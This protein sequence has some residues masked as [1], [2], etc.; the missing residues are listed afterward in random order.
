MRGPAL[1]A[2]VDSLAATVTHA[3]ASG[4]AGDF[5][6]R[7]SVS[8]RH[9][10]APGTLAALRV[11][12][13]DALTPFVLAGHRLDRDDADLMRA[14]V[15]AHPLPESA[16]G[17]ALWQARDWAVA[18]ALHS[19]A[20]GPAVQ[21]PD[22]PPIDPE[23]PW[24][25]WSAEL[26]RYS[27]LALPGLH[28]HVRDQAVARGLDLARGLYRAMLRQDYLTAARLAR[29]Q[30]LDHRDDPFLPSVLDQLEVLAADRPRVLLEVTVAR[31]LGTGER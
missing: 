11:L 10:A 7:A 17:M 19:L 23:D 30:A 9:G 5:S 20:A 6:L 2:E 28:G 15:A 27:S 12:G 26:A 16:A 13:A 31:R 14:A 18:S 22:L 3:L 25:A 24:P 21:P 29:W 1:E 8:D 4:R